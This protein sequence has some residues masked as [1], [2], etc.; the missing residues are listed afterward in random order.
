[1]NLLSLGNRLKYFFRKIESVYGED[2][3]LSIAVGSGDIDYAVNYY[4]NNMFDG[5]SKVD[6]YKEL[7]KNEVACSDSD[8]LYVSSTKKMVDEN[9]IDELLMLFDATPNYKAVLAKSFIRNS[10]KPFEE[11]YPRCCKTITNKRFKIVD[12]YKEVKETEKVK[13]N[14]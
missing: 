4:S 10:Y 13:V 12:R 3:A 11:Q 2:V 14:K 7:I 8:N 5:V 6:I 1:M 9:K